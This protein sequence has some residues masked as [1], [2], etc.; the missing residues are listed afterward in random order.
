MT[1]ISDAVRRRVAAAFFD[2]CAY[3]RSAQEYIPEKLE[4]EHI[5]PRGRGGSDDESNL[6]LA[7]GECNR[8]KATRM[9]GRDPETNRRVLL[10]NPRK[11]RWPDHFRWSES[12]IKVFGTTPCGRATVA[13]LQLNS[14]LWLLVRA[15]WV[16]AGWHPPKASR[17]KKDR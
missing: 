2:C 4:I 3:C 16:A 13:A 1:T 11:Q 6:C 7:C 15:N 17:F 14:R 12:G 8:R 5:R 10:F 9:T